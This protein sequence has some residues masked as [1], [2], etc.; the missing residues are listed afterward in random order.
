L[1]GYDTTKLSLVTQDF[2][3]TVAKLWKYTTAADSDATITGAGYFSDGTEIQAV[4]GGVGDHDRG[5]RRRAH[6][7]HLTRSAET[8]HHH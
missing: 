7:D 5:D 6:R 1:A 4:P 3:G 2:E 8:L